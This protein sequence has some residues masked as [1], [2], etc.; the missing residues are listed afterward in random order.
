MNGL[1]FEKQKNESME[2]FF[3]CITYCWLHPDIRSIEKTKERFSKSF[4][5]NKDNLFELSQK[6]SWEKRAS[7]VDNEKINDTLNDEKKEWLKTR[8]YFH[9]LSLIKLESQ[10]D[11]EEIIH[12][13]LEDSK[14]YLDIN[15]V[16]EN[17]NKLNTITDV[18]KRL[19]QINRITK[20]A[21]ENDKILWERYLSSIGL[22][23]LI[24][25]N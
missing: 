3:A 10:K 23:S 25:K 2:N 20:S 16:D 13:Y 5:K 19:E 17:G 7:L 21:N 1:P 18:S 8:D 15:K 11:L 6:F 12:N 9:E 14:P 22:D 24:D 4:P